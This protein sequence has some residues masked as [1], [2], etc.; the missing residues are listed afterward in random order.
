[1]SVNEPQP[2]NNN[3]TE[4]ND[5]KVITHQQLTQKEENLP[6]IKDIIEINAWTGDKYLPN[7]E[8]F[9]RV[10]IDKEMDAIRKKMN[11]NKPTIV[12]SYK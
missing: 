1:M 10:N 9:K 4:D 8:I 2:E 3:V 12:I 6:L 11:V 5:Y 7:V